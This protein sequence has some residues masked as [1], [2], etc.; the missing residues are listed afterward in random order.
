MPVNIYSTEKRAFIIVP[1]KFKYIIAEILVKK[2]VGFENPAF[3]GEKFFTR[4]ELQC[5]SLFN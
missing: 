5:V 1:R 2:N 3:W 4:C